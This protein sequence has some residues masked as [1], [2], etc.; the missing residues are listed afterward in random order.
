[1][2]SLRPSTRNWYDGLSCSTR[3]TSFV[4]S[5]R[6]LVLLQT[7]NL[8]IPASQLRKYFKLGDHVKVVEG[9]YQGEVGLVVRVEEN[10][11]YIFSDLMQEEV[12]TAAVLCVRD[13]R[14]LLT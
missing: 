14:I 8:E 2:S 12:C 1:M 13:R 7:Q 10:I 9:R 3:R 4:S 6:L 11:A 5:P